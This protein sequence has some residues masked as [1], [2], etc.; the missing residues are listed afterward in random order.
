MKKIVVDMM[1]SDLGLE[2]TKPGVELFHA[3]HPD[4]EL[5]LVGKED[6]LKDIPY[7]KIVNA[8]DVVP[9]TCGAL[10][11]IRRKESSMVVALNTMKAE[12]ADGI[13]SAGATGAFLSAS[14]LMLKKIPGVQRPALLTAFPN[15][16]ADGYTT[17]LDVGASNVNAAE[18]LAQFA[19]MGTVYA[20]AVYNI[21]NPRVCLLSNGSEEG[22]GSPVGKEAYALLKED[23][24]VNFQGNIEGDKLL[25]GLADVV[26]SDGFTGNVMLKTTEGTAKGMGKLLKK[27]FLSKLRCKIGYLFA[28]PAV[29]MLT[30]KLDPSN[31]GGAMLMGVN[32]AVVKAHGNSTGKSFASAMEVLYRLIDGDTTN[33]IKKA[34]E[35][36]SENK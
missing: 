10:E 24:K 1:G 15:I 35:A 23:K 28:K 16:E 11:V 5:I 13:I 36:D 34:F 18:E 8:T 12:G 9:M 4:V 22:K 29:K 2:A 33:K 30:D 21:E 6:E 19:F 17:L 25:K 3:K 20:R 27:G 26:V 31:V 14:T 32:G 7:A